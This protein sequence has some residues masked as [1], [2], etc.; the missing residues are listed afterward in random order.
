[1]NSGSQVGRFKGGDGESYGGCPLGAGL[2][3]GRGGT[4]STVYPQ[5]GLW[6]WNPASAWWW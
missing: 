4:E 2:G 6:R 3:R 5:V 1:M